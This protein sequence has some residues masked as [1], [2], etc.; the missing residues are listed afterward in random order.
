M[1]NVS[2]KDTICIK[3]SPYLTD[4][5][6]ITISPGWNWVGYIPSTGMTV[7]QAFKDLTPL[8]GDIIKSQTLFAQYVAG[9]GWIGNLSFLEPLKGYLLKISNSGT[10]QC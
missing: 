9:I 1:I 2:Q 4:K 7:T 3:G 10:Q 8:N 5:F 6:P